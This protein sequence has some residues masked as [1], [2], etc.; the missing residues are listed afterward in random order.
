[1]KKRSVLLLPLLVLL[2]GCIFPLH[3]VSPD[4]VISSP[5][6]LSDAAS[7]S[8]YDFPLPEVRPEISRPDADPDAV[9]D[10]VP[11]ERTALREP[12][13]AVFWY[14]MADAH[15][16][17]LR[18]QF[19][20]ELENSGIPF[21]EFDAENDRFRQLDQVREAVAGGWN[22]LAVQ[23][24]RDG[25]TEQAEEILTAAGGCPVLFFDRTPDAASFASASGLPSDHVG[26]I[27]TDPDA[28]GRVQ[29]RMIGEYLVRN[30]GTADLNQDG[31]I[32]YTYLIGNRNDDREP[33][34]CRAALD[35][36]NSILAEN[37]Y[38]SLMFIDEENTLGFQADPEG[39]GSS[40]AG[41]AVLFSDLAVFNYENANMIELIAA[42]GDD[43]ALGALTALQASWCNLGD[44]SSV[45]I[46]LFGAGGSSAA[47]M[48]VELGQMTGTV[49]GNSASYARAVL[50]AVR[51]LAEGQSVSVVFSELSAS[52]TD[53]SVSGA[54]PS[55][56]C[57]EPLPV[58]S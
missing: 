14:A 4:P 38:R 15:V 39:T 52:S 11:S 53:F 24:V 41:N 56:L 57:V 34:L 7:V 19:G 44:G 3:A 32:L 21:R 31:Q 37:G 8:V 18:E 43:L 40:A 16:F 36:A 1:M 6:P 47:R 50:G 10:A 35:E 22:V 30:F 42:S 20:P 45:T 23:L 2:S 26:I 5:A 25:S 29:G 27:T 17:Q 33:A 12:K 9:P 48:A 46:P 54:L 13:L 49:E 55:V 58:R 51:G 28:L